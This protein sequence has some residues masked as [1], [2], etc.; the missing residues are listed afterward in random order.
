MAM[1]IPAYGIAFDARQG[2][3]FGPIL[4]PI[5]IGAQIGLLIWA[6]A[7]L[8]DGYTGY[9]KEPVALFLCVFT[10]RSKIDVDVIPVSFPAPRAGF[11]PVMCWA[12]NVVAGGDA[13]DVPQWP[14]WLGP[15][16]A[17]VAH[18][19]VYIIFP[20]H[21]KGLYGDINKIQ[22][23]DFEMRITETRLTR[24]SKDI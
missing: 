22:R 15:L 20:P 23:E 5:F 24:E 13:A 14:Y 2:Q 8:S 6:S 9:S 10:L 11:N 16:A 4:A 19:F 12:A 1:L 17:A 18:A 7:G 3:L 21:H